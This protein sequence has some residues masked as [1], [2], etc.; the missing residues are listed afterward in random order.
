MAVT[1]FVM[2]AVLA[3]VILM[4]RPHPGPLDDVSPLSRSRKALFPL[5][6]IMCGLC[7]TSLFNF[8]VF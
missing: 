8:M 1:G 2:M 7:Y 4:L 3:L 6:P 5:L